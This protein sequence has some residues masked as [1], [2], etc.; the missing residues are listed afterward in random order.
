ML[1]DERVLSVSGTLSGGPRTY[2]LHRRLVF[3]SSSSPVFT[4][5]ETEKAG[6]LCFYVTI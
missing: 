2:R 3:F 1:P 6:R 4:G 5:T